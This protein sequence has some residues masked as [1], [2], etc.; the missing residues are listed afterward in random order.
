[1]FGVTLQ[2]LGRVGELYKGYEDLCGLEP[3]K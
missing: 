2:S 3:A 1:V